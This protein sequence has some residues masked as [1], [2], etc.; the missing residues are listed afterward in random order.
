MLSKSNKLLCQFMQTKMEQI[1][2]CGHVLKCVA[3]P[4]GMT[5]VTQGLT[6]EEFQ[7]K[8]VAMCNDV[9]GADRRVRVYTSETAIRRMQNDQASKIS[10]QHLDKVA[11]LD[12]LYILKNITRGC[13]E[14][15]GGKVK[16]RFENKAVRGVVTACRFLR[17]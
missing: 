16:R 7:E 2:A 8:F 5:V 6:A 15:E 4:G 10:R 3:F 11:S 14:R 17:R 13:S 12:A 9:A 1:S